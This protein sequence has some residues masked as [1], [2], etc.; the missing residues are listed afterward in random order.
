MAIDA[1]RKEKVY[2]QLTQILRGL[3]RVFQEESEN[4]EPSIAW[5]TDLRDDLSVDSVEILDLMNMI[6][7]VFNI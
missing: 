3:L 5:N 1:D 4:K 6:E 7:E 2:V